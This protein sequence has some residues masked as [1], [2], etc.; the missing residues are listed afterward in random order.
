MGENVYKWDLL[1]M[2]QKEVLLRIFSSANMK[3]SFIKIQTIH[4]KWV[5]FTAYKLYLKAAKKKKKALG[6]WKCCKIRPDIM[7]MIAQFC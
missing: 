1:V 4:L 3:I 5:N 2:W 6:W 7:E